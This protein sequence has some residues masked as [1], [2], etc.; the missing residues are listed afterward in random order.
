MP[1]ER[2]GKVQS[3]GE[4]TLGCS[5]GNRGGTETNGA[6]EM[7]RHGVCREADRGRETGVECRQRGEEEWGNIKPEEG[8]WT[9]GPP[10]ESGRQGLLWAPFSRCEQMLRGLK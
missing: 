5:E 4:Q 1:E 2:E 9:R 8:A 7:Q 6:T 3:S 10:P